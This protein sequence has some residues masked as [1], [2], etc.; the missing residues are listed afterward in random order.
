MELF[1]KEKI[2]KLKE[3]IDVLTLSAT[4]IPR[5]L[6][7]SLIGIRDMSVLENPPEDRFPVE[8]YVVEFNEELIKDAILREIARGGQVYFVYNR[9]N[10]I[11][12]MA[13]FVKDLVPGCRVAVAHGQW[14]K[15]N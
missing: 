3:N 7:M 11:E 15:V 9:V 14:K 2:K 5:T 4:P 12:K 13:S 10:G 1:I 6:H 8:T